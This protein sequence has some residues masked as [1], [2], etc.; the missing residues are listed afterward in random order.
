EAAAGEAEEHEAARRLSP[1]GDKSELIRLRD[2]RV[3]L[4]RHS[5]RLR[6]SEND[7]VVANELAHDCGE[8]LDRAEEAFAAAETALVK[9]RDTRV[10]ADLA[11]RLAIGEPCP[12]C[13]RP[14]THAPH[15]PA[16]AELDEAE[17]A[18]Y[19]RRK[20]VERLRRDQQRAEV[21]C[22]KLL[23]AREDTRKAVAELTDTLDGTPEPTEIAGR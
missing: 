14:V 11:G 16:H 9:T 21:R 5:E 15:H 2:A 20:A 22:A 17:W 7:L 19:E 18:V 6:K 8:R 13:L 10:A 1:L 3:D 23:Q 4:D 12:V